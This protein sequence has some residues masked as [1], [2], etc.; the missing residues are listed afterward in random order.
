[1]PSSLTGLVILISTS[2]VLLYLEKT[3]PNW[4]VKLSIYERKCFYNLHL[5]LPAKCSQEKD[6]EYEWAVLIL[7][8]QP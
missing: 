7:R 3:E 1:M 2:K 4:K 8:A 5:S 6:G